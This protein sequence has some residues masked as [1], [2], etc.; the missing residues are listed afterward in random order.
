M[1][2]SWP[3][4]NEKPLGASP[5]VF[6]HSIRSGTRRLPAVPGIFLCLSVARKQ[7]KSFRS[8]PY[9]AGGAA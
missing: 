5:R 8:F 4:E 3:P 6:F 7:G 2:A 9:L 1:I